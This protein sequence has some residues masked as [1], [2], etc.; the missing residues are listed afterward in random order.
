MSTTATATTTGQVR[1]PSAPVRWFGQFVFRYRDY[2][3]PLVLLAA[4]LFTRP[5]PFFGSERLDA[6]TDALGVLLALLGQSIRVLVIGYAYIVRGGVNKEVAAP[7]LVREG[8]YAHSRNP[9]YMGNFFLLL[10]LAV[11]YNSV[12]VYCVGLPILYFGLLSIVRAEEDFLARKFGEEYADYCRTVNRF[13]PGLRGMRTTLGSMRFDWKRVLRK[14]YGTTFAWTSAALALMSIEAVTW[15][16]WAGSVT[17]LKRYAAVWLC[18]V[19]LYSFVR[20]LKKT[21]RLHPT[22]S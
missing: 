7:R 11:I 1:P 6:W 19:A 13:V 5:K 8:F 3:A 14:E 18:L 9:M 2:L 15:Y 20:W 21:R 12:W 10:G 4:L 17:T 22:S 16:G